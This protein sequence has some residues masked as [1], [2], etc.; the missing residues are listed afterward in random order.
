M[1]GVSFASQT[2]ET[3]AFLCIQM[4]TIYWLGEKLTAEVVSQLEGTFTSQTL[5]LFGIALG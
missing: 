3:Y 5:R 2:S 1:I 4:H